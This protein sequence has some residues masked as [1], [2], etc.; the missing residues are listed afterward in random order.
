MNNQLLSTKTEKAIQKFVNNIS[1]NSGI[2]STENMTYLEEVKMNINNAKKR[3][4]T[5][6]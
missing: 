4:E 5:K 1:V 6:Y 2:V 3:N